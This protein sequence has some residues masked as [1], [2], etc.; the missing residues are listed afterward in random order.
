MNKIFWLA[1]YPKS[2]NTWVRILISNLLNNSDQ[3]IDINSLKTHIIASNSNI[4]NHET[5]VNFSDLT[6][7]EIDLLRPGVYKEYLKNRAS[8]V[9][10]KIHDSFKL[11]TLQQ[12]ILPIDVTGGIIHILRNP[13]DIA[14]SLSSHLGCS[15]DKS[16]R[17]L[18]NKKYSFYSS[19]DRGYDQLQQ[20]LGSWTTHTKSWQRCKMPYLLVKYEDMI[21]DTAKQLQRIVEFIGLDY[22]SAAIS[23]AVKFSSMKELQQQESTNGFNEAH[24]NPD[25]FFRNGKIGDGKKSLNPKQQSIIIDTHRKV[26]RE[27]NYL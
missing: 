10:I 14:V 15:F 11:N 26:M 3:P 22:D 9:Y 17:I 23:K 27:Y 20:Y 7:Q 2:G 13:L 12:P 1:S 16:V 5:G 8:N 19:S 25:N 6:N 24:S 18:A 21:S 4:F